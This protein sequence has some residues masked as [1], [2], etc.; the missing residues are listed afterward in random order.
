MSSLLP[1]L[2]TQG[3]S[4]NM[5]IAHHTQSMSSPHLRNHHP[6]GREVTFSPFALA[7]A[8]SQAQN[9]SHS[10]SHIQ[11]FSSSHAPSPSHSSSSVDDP[12]MASVL[13]P[14]TIQFCTPRPAGVQVLAA[15]SVGTPAFPSDPEPKSKPDLSFRTNVHPMEDDSS[16]STWDSVD[17]ILH[18]SVFFPRRLPGLGP[19]GCNI[20]LDEWF[21]PLLQEVDV[22]HVPFCTSHLRL[23]LKTII[24]ITH[25]IFVPCLCVSL[26]TFNLFPHSHYE[27][28][29]GSRCNAFH[30]EFN[31]GYTNLTS[32]SAI[33]NPC[34]TL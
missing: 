3:P 32:I 24:S 25:F 12:E 17:E 30:S 13:V 1:S 4:P 26:S 21:A 29:V 6:R 16:E 28:T 22:D 7:A 18:V 15:H 34:I 33:T 27:S 8:R 2:S 31:R 19:L 11:S 9:Q 10:Q 20:T 14:H 23:L 5:V